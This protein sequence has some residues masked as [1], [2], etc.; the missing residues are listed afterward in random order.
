MLLYSLTLIVDFLHPCPRV[1]P[2]PLNPGD[3]EREEQ[4]IGARGGWEQGWGWMDR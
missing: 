4:G 3:T 2:S 1:V